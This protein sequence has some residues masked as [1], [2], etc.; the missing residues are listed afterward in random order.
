M[1]GRAQQTPGGAEWIGMSSKKIDS[2]PRG[3]LAV[4]KPWEAAYKK[5]QKR[6][7]CERYYPL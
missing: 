1:L 3:R 4:R 2:K 6:T 5:T 7:I